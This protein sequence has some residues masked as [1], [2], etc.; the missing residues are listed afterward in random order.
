MKKNFK[1]MLVALMALV[2]F[3]SAMAQALE[4]TTQYANN[5]LQYKI[6]TLKK[7]TSD[8]T[9]SVEQSDW[10]TR[11]ADKT[12]LTIPGTVKFSLTGTDG[13]GA[14]VNQEITFKVVKVAADA[15]KGL[16]DIATVTFGTADDPCQI[17]SI[18]PGAFEGTSISNLNLTNTKITKLEKLFED[19]NTKL[20]SVTLPIMLWST[21][22]LW[23]LLILM[24]V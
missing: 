6:L 14:A 9:V 5:G 17:T 21:A 3:N 1:L 11:A 23:V 7:A 22:M 15:F 12:A 20:T 24:L 18:D 16:T 2:G 10:N 19:A 8:F 13:D 4:G